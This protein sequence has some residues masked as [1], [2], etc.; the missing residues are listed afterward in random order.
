MSSAPRSSGV[1]RK[2]SSRRASTVKDILCSLPSDEVFGHSQRRELAE[3]VLH[4]ILNGE[5]DRALTPLTDFFYSYWKSYSSG[6]L[7]EVLKQFP[8]IERALYGL[9]TSLQGDRRYRDHYI[10]SFCNF[11][12]GCQILA[13]SID[14]VDRE[15]I[16]RELWKVEN[17]PLD[18]PFTTPYLATGRLFFLWKLMTHFQDIGI[19]G[20]HQRH[21][22]HSLSEF[23]DRFGFELITETLRADDYVRA[24]LSYYAICMARLYKTGIENQNGLYYHDNE[25]DELLYRAVLQSFSERHHAAIGAVCLLRWLE[26]RFQKKNEEAHYRGPEYYE[27]YIKNVLECDIARAS[28]GILLHGLKHED[29][30]QLY[31]VSLDKLPLTWLAIV[32]DEL[33]EF[34]RPEG[35]DNRLVAQML[36]WPRI[37]ST[38]ADVNKGCFSLSLMLAC[39]Y[40]RREDIIVLLGQ[41]QTFL[42]TNKQRLPWTNRIENWHGLNDPDL[43]QHYKSYLQALWNDRRERLPKRLNFNLT[44][45]GRIGYSA[46]LHIKVS[47][48]KDWHDTLKLS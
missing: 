46:S 44:G 23:F 11:I 5:L 38:E 6:E 1:Y 41:R 16:L 39:K 22:T 48:G 33:Q 36:C 37:L 26:Q 9:E 13:K 14:S 40:P 21:I 18:I 28:L 47:L 12:F 2:I 25:Y 43:R 4:A 27:A 7:A 15:K 35:I 30:P 34:L 45:S 29:F 17:E 20:E 32:C 31:P 24:Q 19:P 8:A 42:E 10:H 3:Q